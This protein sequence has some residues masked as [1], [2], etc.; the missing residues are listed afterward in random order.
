M[1]EVQRDQIRQRVW[2]AERVA[3][4]YIW[5]VLE[6]ALDT[7]PITTKMSATFSIGVSKM[8]GSS[9]DMYQGPT[10]MAEIYSQ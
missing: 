7:A 2:D 1:S 10:H 9:E 8:V 5:A 6:Q 4:W 3:G